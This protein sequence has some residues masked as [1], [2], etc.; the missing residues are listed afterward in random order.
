MLFVAQAW[1]VASKNAVASSADLLP[2]RETIREVVQDAHEWLIE[3]NVELP[4]WLR[5]DDSENPDDHG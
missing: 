1:F 2:D 3:Q 4:N 5:E